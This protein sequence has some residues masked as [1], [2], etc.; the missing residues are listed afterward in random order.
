MNQ[1]VLLRRL[2]LAA[3][4]SAAL[5]VPVARA[6]ERGALEQLRETTLAL[7]DA[8]VDQG[9]LTREKADHLVREAQRKAQEKVAASPPTAP[10][11]LAAPSDGTV[12]VPYVPE[13]VKNEIREQL[14]QEVLAQAKNERWAQPNAIPEWLDRIKLE[15][16]IRVR[17][18]YD[19]LADENTAP[20]GY[21]FP[22]DV[23]QPGLGL[24]G[25]ATRA[26]DLADARAPFS[27]NTQ[28]ERE[29]LRARARLGLLAKVSDSW[30]AGLR[31][32]TGNTTDRVSTN[33]TLG[34]NFNKYQFVVDRAYLRYEPFEWLSA[35][36]GRIPSP[37]FG[38]DLMWDEDLNFEGV[39]LTLKPKIT[40]SFSPYL[41][42][43]YFPVK[44]R[45]PPAGQSRALA[46]AQLG[47]Q[48]SLNPRHSMKLGA[49]VFDFSR[50]EGRLEPDSSFDAILQLPI[51]PTYGNS[52]YEAGLRQRGNTLFRT[53]SRLDNSTTNLWGLASRFRP[54]NVTFSY[55]WASFDPVH[56]VMT[57]DWVTNL[58]FDP[59]EIE[60]RS[61]LRLTDA[62]DDG[63][64]F[65]LTV[66]MP[67]VKD[68]HDWQVFAAYRYLGSDA[69]I[70]AFTD[71]DFGFGGTN[72]KGYILGF[73]YGLDRNVGL[74][75][76]WLSADS[77]SSPS[78]AKG[79]KFSSDV[80]QADVNL[81]F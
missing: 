43:G 37:W 60:R 1:P 45:N 71:S 19:W 63:Y 65:K 20:Q 48:W 55:D 61:G 41:T 24:S 67:V 44:E 49:A 23:P 81:R 18:Q 13:I 50:F 73:S 14:K 76:R 79:G 22:D 69:T 46:G 4:L 30:S 77:I 31:L 32:A 72:Q 51:A 21:V 3:M 17:Y 7:I 28:R 64:Q 27:T 54:L 53:N 33:Q 80:L 66:G 40:E 70:D 36:G 52:V 6:D 26:A 34:Q 74:N 2:A 35:T 68:I 75:V 78:M 16:D 29:R 58:E 10:A 39:A 9:I 62:R 15:G 56:V 5:S 38:T 59:K 42:A 47:L 11:A 57:A 12:R 8:L 25:A